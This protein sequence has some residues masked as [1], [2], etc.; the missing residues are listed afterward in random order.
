MYLNQRTVTIKL[1]RE[2]IVDIMILCAMI[3]GKW[4]KIHDKIQDQL[5]EADAKF[6]REIANNE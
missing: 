6:I 1:K 2:Q 3:G 5:K 4:I